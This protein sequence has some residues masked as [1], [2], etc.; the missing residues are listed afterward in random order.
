METLNIWKV[1]V[2]KEGGTYQNRYTL[3]KEAQAYFY[4]R[5]I[6]IGAPYTKRLLLNGKVIARSKGI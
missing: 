2:R 5:C 6:N 1:Q 3:H 4:Y